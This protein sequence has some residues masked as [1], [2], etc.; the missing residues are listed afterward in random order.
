MKKI[1]NLFI[2]NKYRIFYLFL[3]ILL[4]IIYTYILMIKIIWMLDWP[5]ESKMSIIRDS[6]LIIITTFIISNIILFILN[7][8]NKMKISYLF[9][10]LIIFS[11]IYII[12]FQN[13]Y[14]SYYNNFWM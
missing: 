1:W 7:I 9:Y 5:Y 14:K 4:S 2:K 10:Y 6:W 12:Y 11:A 3:T 8:K 13:I